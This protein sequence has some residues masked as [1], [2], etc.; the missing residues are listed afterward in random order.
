ME[1]QDVCGSKAK[2]VKP[3][4]VTIVFN[5]LL[6]L[7]G[8]DAK[9]VI[10]GMSVK[11]NFTPYKIS[12][13]NHE[14][15]RGRMCGDR[16]VLINEKQDAGIKWFAYLAPSWSRLC[17]VWDLIDVVTGTRVAKKEGGLKAG[18]PIT[19]LYHRSPQREV[20]AAC[21][22][23]EPCDR[24][25]NVHYT[26]DSPS[27]SFYKYGSD[28]VGT[29]GNLTLIHKVNYDAGMRKLTDTATPGA[30]KNAINKSYVD[31]MDEKHSNEQILARNIAK[32]MIKDKLDSLAESIAKASF[33]ELEEVNPHLSGGRVENHLGKTTLSSPDRDSNLDLPVLSSGAHHDKRV[34]QLRHPSGLSEEDANSLFVRNIGFPSSPSDATPT[35]YVY[36]LACG[37]VYIYLY[38]HPVRLDA[39]YFEL[40]F[41][42]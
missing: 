34:S 5:T 24:R 26:P 30:G 25:A 1:G 32:N 29:E 28:T 7:D 4:A 17:E 3:L 33:V 16:M 36:L 11:N 38:S 20:N 21:S 39:R 6:P 14:I 13:T 41:N 12:L 18:E 19:T 22:G 35:Y 10:V 37:F 23:T 15:S 8:V 9:R 27:E 2:P 31:K 42:R 40:T